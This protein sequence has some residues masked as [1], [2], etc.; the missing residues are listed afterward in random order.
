[1]PGKPSRK[2]GSNRKKKESKHKTFLRNKFE[3]RHIDQVWED[4]RKVASQV[5]EPG[6]TGPLG[7]T[8]NAELDEDVPGL[9]RHYCIPCGRYFRTL[10]LSCPHTCR[11]KMLMNTP[12]PHNQK[13]ADSAGGLGAPDNGRTL[14]P[15][16]QAMEV[17]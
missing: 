5:H 7:T 10:M 13:D 1:M 16:P 9:G 6:K 12:R 17:S 11:V 14:R 3:T 2:T 4:V 15:R 8:A